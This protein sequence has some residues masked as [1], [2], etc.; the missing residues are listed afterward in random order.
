MRIARKNIFI[1]II[2]MIVWCLILLILINYIDIFLLINRSIHI[3]KRKAFKISVDDDDY[4]IIISFNIVMW[5]IFNTIKNKHIEFQLKIL[6]YYFN[7]RCPMNEVHIQFSH[8]AQRELFSKSCRFLL[9]TTVKADGK[10]HLKTHIFN[11]F[12]VYTTRTKHNK[13]GSPGAKS[14]FL[15]LLLTFLFWM[16]YFGLYFSSVVRSCIMFFNKF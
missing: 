2:I 11:T 4:G 3:W 1:N 13:W 9:Y 10:N 8:L 7:C 5:Y 6:T 12:T 15:F 16:L 14:T